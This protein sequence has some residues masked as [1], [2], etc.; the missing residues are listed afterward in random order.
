MDE[1]SKDYARIVNRRH[2]DRVNNLLKD[3]VEQGATLDLTG[4]VNESQNFISPV[5]LSDIPAGAK[6]ME[7]E[8]FGPLLPVITFKEKE[9]VVNQINSRPK[10]LALYIFSQKRAFRN[11]ILKNTSA[12]GV[13]INECVLQFTHPNLPFGGVNNSGIGKS[14]GYSG[15]L[16]FSNEKPVLK[17]KNGWSG[18]YLLYPPYTQKMKKV[19]DI[20]LKWF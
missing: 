14:H 3:A 13:C 9:E 11:Y 7:E 2:F 20:L 17:Q 10:P 16:A 12:G 6:I 4:S 18:P 1:S 5:I 15:F 8:I 19:V